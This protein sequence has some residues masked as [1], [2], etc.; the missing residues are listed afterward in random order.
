DRLLPTS[1]LEMQLRLA[2]PAGSA[3]FGDDLAPVDPVTLLDEELVQMGIGGDPAAR[4]LD[5]DEVA[6]AAQLVAGVGDGSAVDRSD[7][8]TSRRRDVDPVIMAAARRD[9]IA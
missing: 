3:D 1:Q 5:Q 4:M 8:S 9:P 6:V 7:R 2:D